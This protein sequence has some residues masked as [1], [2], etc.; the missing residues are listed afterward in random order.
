[1]LDIEEENALSCHSEKLAIAFVLIIVIY[2]CHDGP[3][4]YMCDFDIVLVDN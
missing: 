3:S 4:Y 1:L 2:I